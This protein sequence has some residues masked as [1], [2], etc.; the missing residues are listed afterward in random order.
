MSE[1]KPNWKKKPKIY[2]KLY[3][4]PKEVYLRGIPGWDQ[5][6]NNKIAKIAHRRK[7]KK[8][9]KKI[10]QELWDNKFS[11]SKRDNSGIKITKFKSSN[12][13]IEKKS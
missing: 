8:K 6:E 13:V 11:P 9:K 5:N 1:N 7:S 2:N 12:E 4:S 10:N 3:Q